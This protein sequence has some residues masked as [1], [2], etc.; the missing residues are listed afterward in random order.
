[1]SFDYKRYLASRE[2]ALLKEQIRHRSRGKC[3]RCPSGDYESTHHVTYERMG[4]ERLDDLLAVCNAC[5]EY[6][7]GKTHVDP[8]VAH[9]AA[10]MF[11]QDGGSWV[12]ACPVCGLD[13]SHIRSAFT[14]I[15]TDPD[16]GKCYDGTEVR[17]MAASRRS[18]LVIQFDGE[19]EHA[20]EI[21][22]QQ[23]KGQNLACVIVI[24]SLSIGDTDFEAFRRD[25]E[26]EQLGAAS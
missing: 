19:C 21:E 24:P 23:R 4:N 3:E 8:R 12:V 1:M 22:I 16:E 20:W 15:G 25:V 18:S 17:G 26:A 6:L 13:Y 7:S 2:W 11:A 5:H 9:L 14:R 10:G